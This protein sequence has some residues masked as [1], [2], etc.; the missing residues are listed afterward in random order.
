[1]N[2][3]RVEPLTIPRSQ[4]ISRITKIVHNIVRLLSRRCDIRGKSK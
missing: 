1:M 2:P 4:R 3:P